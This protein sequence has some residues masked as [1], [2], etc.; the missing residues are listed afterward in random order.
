MEAR[1]EEYPTQTFTNTAGSYVFGANGATSQISLTGL[2]TSQGSTGFPFAD[3][4]LGDVTG[5]TLA[6]PADIRTS[7]WQWGVFTQDSWKITRKLTVDYGIRWDYGT[8]AKEQYGRNANFNPTIP[9]SSAAGHPGGSIFEA[10]CNCAFAKSYPFAVGPRLGAA[11]QINSKTVLRGGLGI[12]YTATPGVAGSASNTA[13]GGSPAFGQWLFQL[14]DGIPTYV[15]PQWPRFDANVGL[16]LNAVATAPAYLD[17]NAGRPARQVQFSLGLQRE[18]GRNLIVEAS[19]VGS[20]GVWWSPGLGQQATPGFND[21]S[22][23]L[24]ARYGFTIGNSTDKRL[25]TTPW[26]NL[27]A[28]D[29]SLLASRRVFLPYPNYDQGQT[30]R[31]IIRAFPQYNNAIAPGNSPLGK[32]WYDALQLVVT[33]RLSHG[34]S[35]NANYTFSKTLQEMNE[36]DVFNYGLG[37]TLS[38]N[39]YPHQLRLSAEYTVPKLRLAKIISAIVSDWGMGWY[40]QYQSAAALA[41]PTSAAVDPISNYLGRGPGP[42]QLLS[43]QSIWSTDWTDLGGVHHN[44]PIDIN[45]HCFDPT[46]T[47][48]LNKNAWQPVPDGQWAA[49]QATAIRYFRGIRQPQENVSFSRNFRMTETIN[50]QIRAEWSNAFNRLRYGGTGLAPVTI[51]SFTAAPTQNALGQF[52][53]GFGTINPLSGTSGQRS[54]QIVARLQF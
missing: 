42:A 41:L 34:L 27:S 4:L 46:K 38:P 23:A 6:V 40:V 15:T 54:G 31:Q 50:L 39:D 5:V 14:K 7:K 22:D 10:T 28:A 52:T 2:T 12:V 48:V 29:L 36:P 3:Y 18:I 1:Y 11:F 9:N 8:Y 16:P 37:K 43:G 51:G 32:T 30:P 45:C 24:L 49:N 26:R 21:I 25:L 53:G 44:D 19:Y 17:P 20:R 33:K 13:T 35:L 47:I